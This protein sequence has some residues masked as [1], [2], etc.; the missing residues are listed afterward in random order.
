MAA[1][2]LRC[3]PPAPRRPRAFFWEPA[4]PASLSA[5]LRRS[6][7]PPRPSTTCR[8]ADLSWASD[9]ATKSRSKPSTEWYGKPLTR[10]R[11]TVELIRRLLHDGRVRYQGETVCVENFD[12]WFTPR[13]RKMPIYLSAVFPRMVGLCGEIADGVIL[14]RST[15]ATAAQVRKQLADGALRAGR[16][17]GEVTVTSLLPTLVGETRQQALDAL[18]PG[19]AFYAGF[20]PRYNRLMAEHGFAD[21]AAAIASA[22]TR[23]DRDGGERRGNRRHQHR[24]NA[25][26]V[27]RAGRG[28]S[29]I[30]DRPANPEPLCSRSRIQGQVRGR[31]PGLR[32]L[33]RLPDRPKVDHPVAIGD[34]FGAAI[35]TG[36]LPSHDARGHARLSPP[37]RR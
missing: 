20:F 18:R 15:L 2:S 4:S 10:I 37:K 35:P 24:R 5:R 36:H 28:V 14:T 13:R 11:E 12:L 3:W 17:P 19:L 21:E 27:P 26:A 22:W 29:A 25:G 6:R 30:G 23:G 32:A 1:I 33:R 9:R 34:A 16:D 7:W 31:D 8:P